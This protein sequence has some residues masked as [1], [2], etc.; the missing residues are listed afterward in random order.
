MFME[1]KY[2]LMLK[3]HNKT[4]LKYLCF[5]YGT[6]QSCFTYKG[7][8][9]YWVSHLSKHGKDIT[10][11]IIFESDDRDSVSLE[12]IKLSKEWD[13]VNSTEY[14]NLT[15][16]DAQTTA[17]PL[18]RPEVR[19][20]R[21]Q[22]YKDRIKRDGLTVKEKLSRLKAVK[23][24]QTPDVRKRAINTL[25]ARQQLGIFTEKEQQ[26]GLNRHNRIKE[27]GFT[28]S[29]LKAHKE[30]KLLQL[31]KTM[32]ER[33]QN[34]NYTDPRRGKLG[35]E[36]FGETYNGPWNKGKTVYELKGKDY[37]DPRCKPF[38]IT[39]NSGAKLYKNEREFLTE[40]KFSQPILTKLKRYGKYVVKRQA[41]TKHAFEHGETIY[42]K[43]LR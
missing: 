38:E 1:K 28:E 7:S 18:C 39:S 42:Y 32:K 4:K 10:T 9:V 36:I 25:I 22:S 23:A 33:L 24:M 40:T 43:E 14:A 13:I 15:I 41:N 5:H 21:L 16:E 37:T 29:E 26:R 3:T 2:F 35:K 6:I 31:G 8:G 17:E 34:P 12:G 30:V 20:K 19:K 27:C 11:E